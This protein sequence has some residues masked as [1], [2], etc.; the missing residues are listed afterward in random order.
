M[1]IA[2]MSKSELD[3]LSKQVNEQKEKIHQEEINKRKEQVNLKLE[4]LREHKDLILSLIE[5]TRT[6]CSD[7]NPC[8]GYGSAEYGARCNKCHLIEILN[9]EWSNEFEVS[10]DV[11]I[12]RID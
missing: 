12:S 3:D 6:S 2:K 5:H 1:D 10:I 4:K 11:T 7:N 8:N 9:N